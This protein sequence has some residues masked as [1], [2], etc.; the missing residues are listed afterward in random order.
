MT[1]A[2]LERT[3]IRNPILLLSVL[4]WIFLVTEPGC[5]MLHMHHGA[6]MPGMETYSLKMMLAHNS[7]ISFAAWWAVMVA[8]MMGPMLAHPI[9]HIWARSFASHRITS[10]ALYVTGYGVVWMM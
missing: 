4:A 7:P 3:R 2:A 8:A 9:Q 10:V 1:P 5:M 6:A